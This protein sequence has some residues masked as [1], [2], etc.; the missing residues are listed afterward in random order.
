MQSNWAQFHV[1]LQGSSKRKYNCT[2]TQQKSG[3]IVMSQR[4]LLTSPCIDLRAFS[5]PQLH[6]NP[7]TYYFKYPPFT[8]VEF[9]RLCYYLRQ[10]FLNCIKQLMHGFP[11]KIPCFVV[12]KR[13]WSWNDVV[14]C[15]ALCCLKTAVQ[16]K[17][18]KAWEN[19]FIIYNV[20]LMGNVQSLKNKSLRH[21][22]SR[23]HLFH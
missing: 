18:C 8:C 14:W 10:I 13:G 7:A 17:Y 4:S 9:R 1:L 15:A 19:S 12:I 16:A 3:Y 21:L 22:E 5:F 2:V 6:N 11:E 23:Q 20:A